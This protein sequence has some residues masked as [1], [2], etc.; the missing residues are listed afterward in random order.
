M[1][2][3]IKRQVKKNHEQAAITIQGVSFGRTAALIITI[4]N[5]QEKY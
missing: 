3:C 1:P 5:K 4:I 2:R